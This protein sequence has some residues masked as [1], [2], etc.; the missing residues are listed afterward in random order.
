M[1]GHSRKGNFLPTVDAYPIP[2]N[3][4]NGFSNKAKVVYEFDPA[5]ITDSYLYPAIAR[6]FRKTG[7]QWV[8]Q[9]AYDPTFMAWANTEYQT[10]YLQFGLY[11]PKKR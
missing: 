2:F 1:A 3:N 6:T 9:F 5:D 7:F 4:I 8:T 10:H 11:S